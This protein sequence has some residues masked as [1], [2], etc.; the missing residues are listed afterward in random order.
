MNL[1][2]TKKNPIQSDLVSVIL[3]FNHFLLYIKH[4]QTLA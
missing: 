1:I 2:M 3:S 4:F